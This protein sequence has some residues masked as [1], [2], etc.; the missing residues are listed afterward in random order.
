MPDLTF[1][2]LTT[3]QAQA[4]LAAHEDIVNPVAEVTS[5]PEEIM[6]SMTQLRSDS[7]VMPSAVQRSGEVVAYR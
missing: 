5:T 1:R 2:D 3:M 6:A 4:L 7:A